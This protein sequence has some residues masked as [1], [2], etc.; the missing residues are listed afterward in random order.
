MGVLCIYLDSVFKVQL[1]LY[2]DYTQISFPLCVAEINPIFSTISE[3]FFFFIIREKFLKLI[4]CQTFLLQTAMK[5]LF[6]T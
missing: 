5:V 1:M 2:W 3:S 6:S 4:V